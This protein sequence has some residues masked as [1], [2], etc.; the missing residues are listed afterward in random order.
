MNFNPSP[1]Q[2]EVKYFHKKCQYKIFL[3][4]KTLKL[5]KIEI[6]KKKKTRRTT[7]CNLTKT[8]ESEV[9]Y[10]KCRYMIMSVK[11]VMSHSKVY[12]AFL[13]VVM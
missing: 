3:I 1:R 2:N 7:V 5:A 8:S 6:P 11:N 12:F 4:E 10:R 9:S 13:K